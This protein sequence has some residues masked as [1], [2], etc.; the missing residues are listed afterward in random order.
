MNRYWLMKLTDYDIHNKIETWKCMS[1]STN[2][3]GELRN[4]LS[5]GF[6]IYDLKENRVVET[7]L[8]LHKWLQDKG[9]L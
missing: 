3:P 1:I 8:D 4:F 7:N 2:K 5:N 6:R 9:L